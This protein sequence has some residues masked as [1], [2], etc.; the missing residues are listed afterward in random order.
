M[1][2]IPKQ[3]GLF[4][5]HILPGLFPLLNMDG[6]IPGGCSWA[7]FLGLEVLAIVINVAK[8][9]EARKS[10]RYFAIMAFASL[11]GMIVQQIV[12]DTP[13]TPKELGAA[14]LIFKGIINTGIVAIVYGSAANR[15]ERKKA[16]EEDRKT[17]EP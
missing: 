8:I 4:L 3:G 11:A 2:H 1:K 10:T 15:A 6:Y 9:K 5:I 7:I 12:Q 13:S 16:A 17:M 14:V